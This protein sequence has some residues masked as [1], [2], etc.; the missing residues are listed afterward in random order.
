MASSAFG[1][2]S[3]ELS[4]VE[5]WEVPEVREETPQP[6]PRRRRRVLRSPIYEHP[7]H[8][9]SSV[10][11][12]PLVQSP[13]PDHEV[14][15]REQSLESIGANMGYAQGSRERISSGGRRVFRARGSGQGVR[16]EN[17]AVDPNELEGEAEDEE[18]EENEEGEDDEEVGDGRARVR[19][20]GD[21]E[22]SSSEG[23][24][25]PHMV[26]THTR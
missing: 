13:S 7:F 17:P 14:P 3:D 5:Y 12:E 10:T 20:E 4:P 24:A 2:H 18:G 22:S 21:I 6:A 23:D 15:L 9:Q 11:P 19:E 26:R 1:I 16:V 8:E 25:D